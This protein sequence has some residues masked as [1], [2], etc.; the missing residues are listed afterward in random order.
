MSDREFEMLTLSNGIRVIH[1]QVKSTKVAHCCLML[2]IGSRDEQ[3]GEE[4][5]AHFWEH[6][7]FKG[8]KK[9][10]AYHVINRLESL[11]G[12]LNAYTTKEKICFYTAILDTHLDKAVDLL[13]D[14]TFNSVFP[15]NQITKE[16]QVILEEMSM[17]LDSPEDA[18]QDDLDELIFADHSLGVN[19]LGTKESVNRFSQNDFL[20]FL[21]EN[22]DTSRLILSSVGSYSFSKLVRLA[23]KHLEQIDHLT[24][25]RKRS[26]VNGYYPKDI[27]K[28]K[29]ILQAHCA[30][31]TRSFKV[32]DKRRVPFFMLNNILGGPGMN[33]RLNMALREKKGYVYSVD[34]NY[35]AYIDTGIASIFFA[36][37]SG[38]VDKCRAAVLTELMKL[39]EKPLGSLQLHAAKEQLMGQLAISEENNSNLMLTLAKSML[40]LETVESL[41]SIFDKIRNTTASDLMGLANEVFQENQL[42]TLVFRPLMD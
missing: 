1:K 34:S 41:E 36:T 5:I 13:A 9:R 27:H 17:Y 25:A 3:T 22:M 42:S 33:S 40:D 6:M 28:D 15:E 8:T 38:K 23:K 2:D 4:G 7:A 31:G 12:E 14:I 18:I 20:K 37:E 24:K 29:S 21:G 11:G 30:L 10:K 16:R 39:R 26:L 35:S 19:I 32:S